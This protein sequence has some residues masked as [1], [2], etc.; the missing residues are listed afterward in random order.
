[1]RRKKQQKY[2]KHL[3]MQQLFNNGVEHGNNL[4][5][6]LHLE[7]GSGF[8]ILS[9]QRKM[10]FRFCSRKLAPGSKRKDTKFCKAI[11]ASIGLAIML[12]HLASGDPR[13]WCTL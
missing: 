4:L 9:G 8:R 12:R 3:W 7:D 13:V 5:H 10:T 11:P 1:M 6:G 2:A